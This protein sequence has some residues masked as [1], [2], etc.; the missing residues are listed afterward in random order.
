[1][2]GVRQPPRTWLIWLTFVI[3]L[4]LS[5]IA[6]PEPLVFGRPLWLSLLVVYWTLYLP[7]RVSMLTA[8]LLGLAAD[9]LY[10]TLL[11]QN[12]LVLTLV[13]F[14]VLLLQQR[15]RVFPSWQQGPVLLVILGLSRLVELWLYVLSGQPPPPTMEFL[16]PV[17]VSA[18]L[19]PWLRAALQGLRQYCRMY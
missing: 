1:M 4:V 13:S 7:Q 8:W 14:F 19:W 11:G 9:V 12:A 2:K 17:L 16:L 15:L 6:M 18:L 10:G 3:G 5:V